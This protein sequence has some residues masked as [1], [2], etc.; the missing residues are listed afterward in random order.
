MVFEQLVLSKGCCADCTF[1]REV[2]GLQSFH[3]IFGDVVEQLPLELFATH[4][5]TALILAF[6]G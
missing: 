3:M 4:G 2:S 1:V 6:V 5:A